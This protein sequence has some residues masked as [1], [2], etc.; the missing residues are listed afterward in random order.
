MVS[1]NVMRREIFHT[2]AL[3]LAEHDCGDQCRNTGINMNNGAASKIQYS[4]ITEETAP[5]PSM[6]SANIRRWTKGR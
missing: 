2:E 1:P 6:L 4:S 5:T 3:A